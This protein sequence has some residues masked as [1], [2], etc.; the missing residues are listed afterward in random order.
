MAAALIAAIG[1]LGAMPAIVVF[2][3]L[4]C[5]RYPGA[6]G[7][8]RLIAAR[9]SRAPRRPLHRPAPSL[10]FGFAL[11]APGG[12]LIANSLAKRPPPG[13]LASS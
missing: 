12:D 9:R 1:L 13:L 5:G 10:R 6:D 2:A 11:V 4:F 7:L 8:D 3:L